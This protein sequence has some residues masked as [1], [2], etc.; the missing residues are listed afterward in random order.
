M[1]SFASSATTGGAVAHASMPGPKEKRKRERER[2][3]TMVIT[4]AHVS[5]H[6]A[7]K[8]PGPTYGSSHVTSYLTELSKVVT[9]I[10]IL[11]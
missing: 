3:R 6:G 7:R 11:F 2:D 10:D 5:T 8:L 9:E 1:A 4:M